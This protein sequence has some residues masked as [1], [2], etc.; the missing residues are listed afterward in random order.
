MILE[1]GA[2]GARAAS[3]PPEPAAKLGNDPVITVPGPVH[4]SATP[5]IRAVAKH[6]RAV[7]AHVAE[8]HRFMGRVL[9]HAANRATDGRWLARRRSIGPASCRRRIAR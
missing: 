8:R 2:A 4:V 6:A 7:L 9:C 5:A 1:R 3:R